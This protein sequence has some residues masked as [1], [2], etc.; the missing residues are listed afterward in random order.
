MRLSDIM[1]QMGLASYAELGLVI[2][3][4]VFFLIAV[5]TLLLT[6]AGE[7]RQAALIPLRDD[8]HATSAKGQL[9]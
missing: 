6:R 3:L 7:H 1:G 2:F 8:V 9:K 5:R 4:C